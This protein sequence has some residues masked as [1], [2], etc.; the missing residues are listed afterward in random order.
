MQFL[1]E[2]D[3]HDSVASDQHEEQ[4]LAATDA[5]KNP[6]G[7]TKHKDDPLVGAKVPCRHPRHAVAPEPYKDKMMIIMASGTRIKDGQHIVILL[8]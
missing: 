6:G 5:L 8:C 4:F 2:L 7:Q 1:G 3:L